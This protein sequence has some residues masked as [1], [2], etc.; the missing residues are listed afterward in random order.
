MIKDDYSV[1]TE[2]VEKAESK[3]LQNEK[4]A[5]ERILSDCSAFH[6]LKC[7]DEMAVKQRIIR[8]ILYKE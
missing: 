2:R 3:E 5:I 7:V 1:F 6:D 8:E 4:R